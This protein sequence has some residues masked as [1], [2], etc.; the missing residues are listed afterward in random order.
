MIVCG[1]EDL[2][3]LNVEFPQALAGNIEG[4]EYCLYGGQS[5]ICLDVKIGGE[6]R[7]SDLLQGSIILHHKVWDY[8]DSSSESTLS[9]ATV[10]PYPLS[11]SRGGVRKC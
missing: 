2:P 11:C 4:E 6:I 1:P 5:E 9:S 10:W 8:T 7:K 3:D